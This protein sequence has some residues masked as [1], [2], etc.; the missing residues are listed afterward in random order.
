MS[1][2]RSDPGLQ[3]RH[4]KKVCHTECLCLF[5]PGFGQLI[6]QTATDAAR[7]QRVVPDEV[8]AFYQHRMYIILIYVEFAIFTLCPI[9]RRTD[10]ADIFRWCYFYV[11]PLALHVRRIHQFIADFAAEIVVFRCRHTI[12]HCTQKACS[13]TGPVTLEAS[14][15][16]PETSSDENRV[17]R[18]S[19][20]AKITSLQ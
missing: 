20:G 19:I 5:L 9:L 15:A 18:R 4:G 3:V 2:V 11:S 1:R 10:Q 17:S 6:H 12:A 7:I 14:V 13:C 16:I 8:H